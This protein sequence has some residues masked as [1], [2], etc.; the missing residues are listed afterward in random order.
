MKRI[1]LKELGKTPETYGGK[2]VTVKASLSEI[3]IFLDTESEDFAELKAIF[4]GENFK[5][6][7]K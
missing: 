3:P 1:Q 7:R 5:R 4:D 2:T 6:I